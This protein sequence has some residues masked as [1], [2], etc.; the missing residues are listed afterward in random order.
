VKLNGKTIHEDS[1]SFDAATV[2][3]RGERQN[4]EDSLVSSFPIGQE[5]GFAVLADG[6]GGHLSGAVAS[7]LAMSE[8]FSQ[9]KMKEAKLDEGALSIPVV[10][11]EVAEA[12]NKRIADHIKFDGECYGMGSTLLTTVIW[13]NKLYWISIGDSPLL[14]YRDG[15]LRQLNKDHSM[16]PQIDMMVKTGAMTAEAGRNHP[17]RNTLTSALT[18]ENIEMIDC[19]SRPI[20]LLPDDIV[21]AA[22]DGLQ[23]ISN[24]MIAKTL[25]IAQHGHSIDI[26]NALLTAV[27]QLESPDQDNTAIIVIKL[28]PGSYDTGAMDLDALPV[29]ASAED[30]EDDVVAIKSD[31]SP[32]K[33]LEVVSEAKDEK[34]AYWYRGQKYYKD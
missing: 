27:K 30:E 29:L 7:T 34:T 22:S 31:P 33:E 13:R 10:L 25:R 28:N 15:A 5:I 8:A 4:Q 26:A 17:D 2:A 12:A 14:L 1:L 19:P 21:I 11:G 32:E 6:M 9:L 18:G 24:G 20:A 23:F 3:F 16:S